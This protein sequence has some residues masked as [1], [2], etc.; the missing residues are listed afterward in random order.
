[1]LST[2]EMLLFLLKEAGWDGF[3]LDE[4]VL[5]DQRDETGK[6][7]QVEPGLAAFQELFFILGWKA[8]LSCGMQNGKRA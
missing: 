5:W 1:M 3:V 4:A 8:A 6:K 7:G 2:A